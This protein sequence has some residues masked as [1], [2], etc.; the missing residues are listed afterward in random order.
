MHVMIRYVHL[1]ATTSVR[2]MHV[3]HPATG[4]A[5]QVFGIWTRAY[6]INSPHSIRT[7]DT[8]ISWTQHTSRKDTINAEGPRSLYPLVSLSRSFPILLHRLNPASPPPLHAAPRRSP[9]PHPLDVAHQSPPPPPTWRLRQALE[10]G[11]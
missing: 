3:T 5:K 7:V 1:T 8:T 10:A 2:G 4:L 11:V 9:A 6:R